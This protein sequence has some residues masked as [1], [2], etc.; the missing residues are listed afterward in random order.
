LQDEKSS[1]TAMNKLAIP[2]MVFVV[3]IVSDFD[4]TVDISFFRFSR[5]HPKGK[6]KSNIQFPPRD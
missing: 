2:K 6:Y 1:V 5:Y 3:F 4:F